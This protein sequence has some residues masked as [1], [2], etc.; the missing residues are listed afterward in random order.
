[1]L[2]LKKATAKNPDRTCSECGCNET[3]NWGRHWKR[4]HAGMTA[5][6]LVVGR[7]PTFPIDKWFDVLP[8]KQQLKYASSTLVPSQ[9]FTVHTKDEKELKELAMVSSNEAAI[10]N[11][12]WAGER[13]TLVQLAAA[14]VAGSHIG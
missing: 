14:G 2:K 3:A 4:N 1:M 5:S 10:S 8:S 9:G 13:L 7:V 12:D 11:S 6:E